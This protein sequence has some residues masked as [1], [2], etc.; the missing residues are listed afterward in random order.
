MSDPASA[1][2]PLIRRYLFGPVAA[3]RPVLFLRLFLTLLG[4]DILYHFVQ[5]GGRFLPGEFNVAHFDWIDAVQPMP[6]AEL[7]TAMMIIAAGLAI[8]MGLAGSNRLGI[9]A[10][11]VLF[12]YG[13][14]MSLYD[15]YQHHYMLSL[16]ILFVL[17]FPTRRSRGRVAAWAYVLLTIQIALVY[18]CAGIAK[19]E[20]LWLDGYTI[21]KVSHGLRPMFGDNLSNWMI[22]AVGTIVVEVVLAV[23]YLIA[24]AQDRSSSRFYR[25]AGFA[26][27]A[28]AYA[29]HW[30]IEAA[31]LPIGWFTYYMITAA[32]IFMLPKNS[33]EDARDIIRWAL[34]SVIRLLTAGRGSW[35]AATC[36]VSSLVLWIAYIGVGVFLDLPGAVI[37][38]AIVGT[39]LAV[40]VISEVRSGKLQA[41]TA[42]LLACM[43]AIA[44]LW[45]VVV[46]TGRR[47]YYYTSAAAELFLRERQSEAEP[48]FDKAV[49]Y[50]VLTEDKAK[51]YTQL[52]EISQA[53][54]QRSPAIDWF[55]KSLEVVPDQ[56]VAMRQLALLLLQPQIPFRSEI[57]EATQL[58]ERAVEI[59]NRLEPWSLYALAMGYAKSGRISAARD[60]AAEA[61][62]VSR[63]EGNTRISDNLEKWLAS[64][65]RGFEPLPLQTPTMEWARRFIRVVFQDCP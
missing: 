26:G 16:V 47:G 15:R 42:R 55:R 33:V 51:L 8:T 40:W 37:G 11:F 63:R 39:A 22:P 29:L 65:G 34:S 41:A 24:V 4:V 10:L 31:K 19:I 43:V 57:D 53:R 64:S 32:F 38:T 20:P 35:S 56:P 7:Y 2:T 21:R 13:W 25:F 3:A 46:G 17:F 28:L 50:T 30:G 36:V 27:L 61:V 44:A 5:R 58:A 59:T 12:T 54:Q 45:I 23:L 62:E 49:A 48:Y 60:I 52:G 6:T 9:G 1:R 18:I 14:A